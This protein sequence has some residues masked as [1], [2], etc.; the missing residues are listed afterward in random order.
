MA[1]KVSVLICTYNY[2]RFLPECLNSVARQTAPADEIILVDDGSRDDT[3]NVVRRFPMV[4]YVYQENAGKPAAFGR[5]LALS[6]GD[7]ICHLDADD[8]W[9]PNKLERIREVFAQ[10]PVIGGIIHETLHVDG[11]GQPI[12]LPYQVQPFPE[13]AVLTL[14]GSEEVGFLYPLPRARGMVAGN[15]NAVCV[16]RSTATDL[17]PLPPKMGLAVDA[18]LLAG[19]LRYGLFYLPETLATYRHHGNNFWLN[20]PRAVQ[21]IIDMWEYLLHKESYRS[22][23]SRRHTSLL[24]AK[25]LER[26][27]FLASRTGENVWEGACSAM[28][29]PILLL[30]NGLI[31]N[32]KHLVLP[33]L[34][35]IPIKRAAKPPVASSTARGQ[36]SVAR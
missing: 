27:A 32:W 33:W 26:K 24:K 25:I 8:Y 10:N 11:N 14:A 22:R 2:G 9:Q 31:C 19:A 34:C 36:E 13:S 29:V 6:T 28:G 12:K 5:A 15:P 35:L 21:D 3:E 30:R 23:I 16:R 18:I 1:D 4:R 20:N 7:I 17:F